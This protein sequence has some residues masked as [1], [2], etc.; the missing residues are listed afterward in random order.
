LLTEWS[1][2]IEELFAE[3]KA[4]IYT[5]KNRDEI[6]EK[7]NNILTHENKDTQIDARFEI[8]HVFA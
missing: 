6:E 3:S 5:W 7:I 4:S 1:E 8:N 2:E